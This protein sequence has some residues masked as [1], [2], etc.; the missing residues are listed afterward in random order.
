MNNTA[1]RKRG[2]LTSTT[3]NGV[4]TVKVLGNLLEGCVLDLDIE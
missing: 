4:S 3:N 2:F 1:Y